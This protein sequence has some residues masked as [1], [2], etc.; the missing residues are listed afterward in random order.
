MKTLLEQEEVKTQRGLVSQSQPRARRTVVR[1]SPRG[2]K[3]KL[4]KDMSTPGAA[5]AEE[6][7]GGECTVRREGL[8]FTPY[9]VAGGPGNKVPLKRLRVTRGKLVATNKTFKIIDDWSIRANAHRVL[10][11]AWIGTTDFRESSEFI[12]DDSDDDAEGADRAMEEEEDLGNAASAAKPLGE[13][14]DVKYYD[15][16]TPPEKSDP[17]CRQLFSAARACRVAHAS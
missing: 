5:M 15:L 2:P 6:E 13:E 17:V 14:A 1:K 11:G 12:D 7:D 3:T 9:K 16:A 10:D 8:L 4:L